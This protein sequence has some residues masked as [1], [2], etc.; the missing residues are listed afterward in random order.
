MRK[1][2]R[3]G[4]VFQIP[5]SETQIGFGQV[6]AQN[7]PIYYMIAFD[8]I[9]D[10]K[11][12]V[13]IEDVVNAPMI[14]AGNFFDGLFRTGDW[15]VVG[16]VNVKIEVVPFPCFKIYMEGKDYVESWDGTR[17]RLATPE[18]AKL[19]DNSTNYSALWL[20]EAVQAYFGAIPND[21]QYDPLRIGHVLDRQ[22]VI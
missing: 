6:V 18:E 20:Q 5:V 4:D 17:R 12:A 7:K 9:S 15:K 22:C 1:R 2:I 8:F 21:R 16:N 11:S 19:L 10:G 14:F 13:N 3:I